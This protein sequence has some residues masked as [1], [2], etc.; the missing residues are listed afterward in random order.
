MVVVFV[1][2]NDWLVLVWLLAG[3]FGI[4][5]HQWGCPDNYHDNCDDNYHC[6]CCM[7][8]WYAIGLATD[9]ALWRKQQPQQHLVPHSLS[10]VLASA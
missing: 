10:L 3:G 5:N 2:H 8:Q 9:T 1:H 4:A 7:Q 6:C